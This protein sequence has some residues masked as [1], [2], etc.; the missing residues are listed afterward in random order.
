MQRLLEVVVS[1]STGSMKL[2]AAATVT[3]SQIVF[4]LVFALAIA[5]M[6][7]QSAVNVVAWGDNFYGQCN[8]PALRAGLIYVEVAAGF[9]HTMALR[10]DVAVVAWGDNYYGQCNVPALPTGLTYVE[11]ATGGLHAVARRSDGSVI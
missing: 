7:A 3:W 2:R 6:P 4:V 9:S 11:I 1:C 8:V 5:A 10:S